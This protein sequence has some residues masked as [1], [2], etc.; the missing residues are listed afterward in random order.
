VRLGGLHPG[1]AP[2]IAIFGLAILGAAFLLSWGTEVAQVDVPR[3]LALAALAFIAV[4]PEYAVDLFFSFRAG[5]Q[6]EYGAYALANMTGANR[7]LVGAGWSLVVFLAW[8]RRRSRGVT[9]LPDQPRDLVFLLLATAYAILIFV[10]GSLAP[11]DAIVLVGLFGLYLWSTT[12]G[13]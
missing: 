11:W 10:K 4:L 8:I 6:P 13:G 9:L 7:L 12:R 3:G 1:P 5:Q 2:E